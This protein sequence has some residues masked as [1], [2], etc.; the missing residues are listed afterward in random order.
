M[1]TDGNYRRKRTQDWT[2]GNRVKVGFLTLTVTGTK[3]GDYQNTAYTLVSDKGVRYEFEP[4]YGL[5][6][7]S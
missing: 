7:I 3:P 6:R 2:V 1:Y 4:H 5:V